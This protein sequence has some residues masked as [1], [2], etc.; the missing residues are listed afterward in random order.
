MV[1]TFIINSTVLTQ[2][3]ICFFRG[4]LTLRPLLQ[5]SLVLVEE[6]A[7]ENEQVTEEGAV[8]GP[9]GLRSRALLATGRPWDRKPRQVKCSAQKGL[10]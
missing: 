2:A 5:N 10:F 3:L 1:Y 7:T 6:K 9:R 4:K 8:C